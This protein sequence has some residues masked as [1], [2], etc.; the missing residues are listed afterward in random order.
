MSRLTQYHTCLSLW[1]VQLV[2]NNITLPVMF[3]SSSKRWQIKMAVFFASMSNFIV[4]VGTEL[5]YLS[6]D[7]NMPWE[8]RRKL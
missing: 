7:K 5:M 4:S 1:I 2:T 3:G 6:L 8:H